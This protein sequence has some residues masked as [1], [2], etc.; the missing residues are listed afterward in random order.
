MNLFIPNNGGTVNYYHFLLFQ[1]AYLRYIDFIPEII[2]TDLKCSSKCNYI[3]EIL[4]LLYPNSQLIDCNTCPADCVSLKQSPR[5]VSRESGMLPEEYIYLRKILLPLLKN[6]TPKNTYSKYIYI[7]RNDSTRRILL[8]EDSFLKDTIFQKITMDGLSFMEQMYIFN[9]AKYIISPHGAALTNIL[10][11][12]ETVKILEIVT[13]YM[14]KLMHF[15]HISQVLNLNY[16]KYSNIN[17][18]PYNYESN[19]IITEVN[20]LLEFLNSWNKLPA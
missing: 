7:S 16:T 13:P 20:H 6:Y 14:S 1:V 18:Q 19:M 9:Q 10:F 5:P 12:N 17:G 8:N 3:I 2:Y 4:T 11:C 15:E